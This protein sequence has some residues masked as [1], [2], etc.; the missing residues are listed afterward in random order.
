MIVATVTPFDCEGALDLARADGYVDFLVSRQ[1]LAGLMVGGMMSE[2]ITMTVE[3]RASLI[4]RGR[5]NVLQ[6]VCR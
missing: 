5:S 6:A 3:E 4:V 1:M 2:F